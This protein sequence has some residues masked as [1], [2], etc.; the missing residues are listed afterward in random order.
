M[1]CHLVTVNHS[2][3]QKVRL[4]VAQETIPLCR[5]RQ[6][7]DAFISLSFGFKIELE[8]AASLFVPNTSV[9]HKAPLRETELREGKPHFRDKVKIESIAEETKK[10]KPCFRFSP[11]FLFIVSWAPSPRELRRAGPECQRQTATRG[12]AARRSGRRARPRAIHA[13]STPRRPWLG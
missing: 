2:L 7:C 13:C 4:A 1:K 6:L 3:T 10:I 11:P 8:P 9:R 12:G 5:Y